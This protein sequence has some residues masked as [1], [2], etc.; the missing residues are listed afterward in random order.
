[1]KNAVLPHAGWL[2]E[3]RQRACVLR[4]QKM[5]GTTL[6]ISAFFFAYF[7]VMRH[8]QAPITTM[9]LIA[10][11]GWVGFRP[12]AL[13]LYASLWVYVSLAPALLK[14]GRELLSYGL[15]ALLLSVVG[16]AIFWLWPTRVPAFDIDW[17]RHASVA[18]LKTADVAGNACPSLHAA[19][20]VFTAVGFARLLKETGAGVLLRGLN[21]LWCAGI[22]YATLAIRQHVVLDILAGSALG[23]L[24]AG[25]GLL[26][27]R[28][29]PSDQ[30]ERHAS[31]V[32]TTAPARPAD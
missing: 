7:W 8:P 15:S 23:G 14:N 2:R 3:L 26:V 9:P 4:V 19:F 21:L 27:Q 12:A 31:P 30:N 25:L 29:A 16:L 22:L 18:F 24:V 20:A 1:M 5:T 10:L 13:P 11:D 17:T 28:Q 6:G 32:M